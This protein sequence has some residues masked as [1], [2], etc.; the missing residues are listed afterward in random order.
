MITAFLH[1]TTPAPP[2]PALL[3]EANHGGPR[4]RGR[5]STGFTSSFTA[6]GAAELKLFTSGTKRSAGTTS[7][8]RDYEGDKSLGSSCSEG[9]EG[10]VVSGNICWG[11]T[12]TWVFF[13]YLCIFALTPIT[14]QPISFFCINL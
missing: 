2:A 1:F 11:S 12:F 6:A 10:T 5:L 3:T 4:L 13:I 8:P 14:A 9:C 7:R